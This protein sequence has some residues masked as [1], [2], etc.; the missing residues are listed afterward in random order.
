MADRSIKI[1]AGR[2][3]VS[4][5][6]SRLKVGTGGYITLAHASGMVAE[7]TYTCSK[8]GKVM[9]TWQHVLKLDGEEWKL[10]SVEEQNGALVKEFSLTDGT[11][12]AQHVLFLGQSWILIRIFVAPSLLLIFANLP[13]SSCHSRRCDS[14]GSG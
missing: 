2:A 5:G 7:G 8:D 11:L 4:L 13:L 9:V 14:N 6:D 12:S 3:F 1:E 10:S